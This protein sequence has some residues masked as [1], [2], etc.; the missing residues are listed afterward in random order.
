VTDIN[1]CNEIIEEGVNG[2]IIPVASTTDLTKAMK[3]MIADTTNKVYDKKKIRRRIL[4][5]YDRP[6]LW[7]FLLKEYESLQE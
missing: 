6:T 7:R 3:R 5:K 2:T 1:G 4:A